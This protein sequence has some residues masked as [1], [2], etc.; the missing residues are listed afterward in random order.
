MKYIQKRRGYIPMFIVPGGGK[1]HVGLTYN[2]ISKAYLDELGDLNVMKREDEVR[3]GQKM[4]SCFNEL[5]EC[6]GQ[7]E[8]MVE[9][10]KKMIELVMSGK[11]RIDEVIVSTK[12][13]T[14]EEAYDRFITFSMRVRFVLSRYVY[15]KKAR[16]EGVYDAFQEVGIMQKELYDMVGKLIKKYKPMEKKQ[17][18][19]IF[20]KYGLHK[21]DLKP[22]KKMEVIYDQIGDIRNEYV[23]ANLRLV[24]S[25]ANKYAARR[26]IQPMDLIQD[27]NIGLMKAVERFDYKRGF[28]FSTY[29]TWWIRQALSKCIAEE[30][31]GLKVPVHLVE[32]HNKLNR[33]TDELTQRLEREPTYEDIAKELKWTIN[34]TR[35]VSIASKDTISLEKE[36]SSD[37]DTRPMK[38]KIACPNHVPTLKMIVHDELRQKLYESIDQLSERERI[39][40]MGRYGLVDG[41]SMKL[42]ELGS[43]LK[44]T[45]PRIRFIEVNGLEK[46]KNAE[47]NQRN[48]MD[49]LVA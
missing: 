27:G 40:I 22:L 9:E 5:K 43:R 30:G 34:R 16:I 32:Q 36:D 1:N 20:E 37:E 45:A 12:N 18:W 4:E 39:V 2:P 15:D 44:V 7:T 17:S 25:I 8:L 14:Q 24:I 49:Y 6:F 46:L 33:C 10:C 38:D 21:R 42:R 31:C 23:K 41:R 13:T 48:L 29:A 28:R 11:R 47:S 3:L 35:D 26:N 19:M